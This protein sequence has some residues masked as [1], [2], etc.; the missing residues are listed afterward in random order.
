NYTINLYLLYY[1]NKHTNKHTLTIQTNQ[2][3]KYKNTKHTY[4]TNYTHTHLW[5]KLHTHTPMAQTTHTHTHAQLPLRLW[6]RCLPSS[7]IREAYASK[8][9][10]SPHPHT[11]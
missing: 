10:P 4:G 5:H 1:I 6:A 8:P 9:T 7:W 11:T 2:K 3:H